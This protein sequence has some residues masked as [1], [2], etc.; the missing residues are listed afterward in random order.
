VTENDS[1]EKEPDLPAYASSLLQEVISAEAYCC[2]CA[3]VCVCVCVLMFQQLGVRQGPAE[4]RH[5]LLE[6][7]HERDD[8]DSSR[9]HLRVTA[10]VVRQLTAFADALH[11][12]DRLLLRYPSEQAL[13][14]KSKLDS[15]LNSVGAGSR[16]AAADPKPQVKSGA[17]SSSPRTLKSDT[18]PSANRTTK[19]ELETTTI[20]A[21]ALSPGQTI[22]GPRVTPASSRPASESRATEAPNAKRR[23]VKPTEIDPMDPTGTGGKWSDGLDP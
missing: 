15:I 3:C 4:R 19:R 2:R 9:G 6:Q 12:T 20:P 5:V 11:S 7:R 17:S 13:E 22:P 16:Q 10:C 8:V 14:A 1:E 23:K 18:T 21:R